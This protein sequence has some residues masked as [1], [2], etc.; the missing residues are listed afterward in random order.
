MTPLFHN[1]YIIS[2]IIIVNIDSCSNS[3]VMA[4]ILTIVFIRHQKSTNH[5]HQFFV[6]C[7]QSWTFSQVILDTL[8]TSTRPFRCS[9]V[10]GKS[11]PT[12]PTSNGTQWSTRNWW[13]L[14]WSAWGW[15]SQPDKEPRLSKCWEG[16]RMNDGFGV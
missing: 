2:D 8:L 15:L 16:F 1:F 10:T 12:W 9:P 4:P 6:F 14:S 11:R 13:W 7:F 5:Y 3:I